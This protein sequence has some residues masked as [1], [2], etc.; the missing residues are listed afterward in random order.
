[1]VNRSHYLLLFSIT[2]LLGCGHSD[3][4]GHD[5]HAA[6]AER[7][8]H[9]MPFDLERTTHIFTTQPMGGVQQVISDDGDEEQIALIQSHLQEEVERFQVGDF[10]D[11]AMI[12]GDDMPG[13]QQ[14]VTG[15]DKLTITYSD[16]SDGGQI[17]YETAEPD[18]IEAI[19]LWFS[20][21]LSDHG[22]H[23]QSD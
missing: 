14:L 18:L 12:H 5:R 6:V 23:A 17:V 4:T 19:H 11:P 22:N 15:H 10:D 21:Q 3:H 2:L 20:A 9:V 8:A 7:G 16:L 13:L 1:M